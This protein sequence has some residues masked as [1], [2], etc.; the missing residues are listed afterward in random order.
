MEKSEKS[1]PEIEDIA[2]IIKNAR[3]SKGLTQKELASL[4]D[5]ATG[6]IQQYESGK[7]K[8]S[9]EQLIKIML[10]LDIDFSVPNIIFSDVDDILYNLSSKKEFQMLDFKQS[11]EDISKFCDADDIAILTTI[12]EIYPYIDINGKK[13]LK[14]RAIELNKLQKIKNHNGKG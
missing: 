5:C 10:C 14:K 12:L 7:R 2:L 9:Y 8:P 11:L 4:C 3:K 13:E 1:Y 6:T